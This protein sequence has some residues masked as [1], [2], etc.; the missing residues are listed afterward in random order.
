[1]EDNAASGYLAAPC[2]GVPLSNYAMQ[3]VWYKAGYGG[4]ERSEDLGK[5]RGEGGTE[6]GGGAG[7]AVVLL[8]VAHT[9]RT[10]QRMTE[11]PQGGA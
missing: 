4:R 2:Q 11:G 9:C 6:E 7:M 5:G 1:M 10:W 8:Y 3:Q